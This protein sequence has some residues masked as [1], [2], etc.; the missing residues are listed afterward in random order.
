MTTNNQIPLFPPRTIDELVADIDL[1]T[2]EIQELYCQDQVPW[3]IGYSGGKDSSCILQ[4]IWRAIALLP[5]E[6]R[7][8][9]VHVI[10]N[11]TFV[12]NPIVSHWVRGCIDKIN[13]SAQEQTMPFTAHLTHP[14][15]KDTF[16]V[17]LIGKGYP[18]PRQGFRWCT[19]RMKIQPANQFIR[20]TIRANG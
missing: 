10:T 9:T 16:W 13:K 11:Y 17:C 4:L 3:I 20:E 2:S 19:E 1:L 7:R 5:P 8:K 15:T 6:K 18:A 14:A 12:E